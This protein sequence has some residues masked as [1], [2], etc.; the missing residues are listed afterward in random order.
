MTVTNSYTRQPTQ[1]DY[2]SPTQ[3]KFNIVKL[4]KVE[5]FVT[6]V[7]VPGISMGTT[8]QATMLRDLPGPGDKLS[9]ESLTLSFLVD[10]HL[11]NYREIHGW[12][13]GL[14]FPRDHSEFKTLQDAGTDRF[15][16]SSGNVS[17][18][19]GKVNNNTPD[20][21]STFSDATLMILSSKNNAIVEVRFRDIFPVSLG[22]LNYEQQAGDVEYL[23]TSVTFN[24]KLY[25]FA[26]VG[27]STTTV[28]TT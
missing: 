26:T 16:T 20:E 28:T 6:S 27:S 2:A 9:Y 5:Y 14:G 23:T 25:E 10:E 18:E 21:G 1:L 3:F 22:G 24:Y 8:T 12:L 11:E 7:N 15:P 4:P 19:A 17:T 13:T